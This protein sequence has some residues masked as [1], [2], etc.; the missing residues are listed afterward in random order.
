MCLSRNVTTLRRPCS[1]KVSV[2]EGFENISVPTFHKIA[3]L[4]HCPQR[5]NFAKICR[6]KRMKTKTT[7]SNYY[8]Y[9]YA[10]L[11]PCRLIARSIIAANL[12]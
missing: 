3:V 6:R 8:V 12:I 5:M 1:V 2:E 7:R 9:M 10:K 11:K 4:S